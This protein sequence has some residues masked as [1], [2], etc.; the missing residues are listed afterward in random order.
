MFAQRAVPPKERVVEFR[1]RA[2]DGLLPVGQLLA[3]SWFREG[4]FVDARS[5]SKGHG[6]T[7]GMKR[8]GFHGQPASHGHSLSHRSMGSAGG[9]QG[10]GSRVL[11]GKKMAGRMGNEFVTIQ[12]LK[13]MKLDDEN[14]LIVVKGMVAGPKGRLVRLQDAKKKPWQRDDLKL[15]M[16][17][18]PSP[19]IMDEAIQDSAGNPQPLSG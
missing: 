9:S 14:G 6:F 17:L 15:P 5:E 11:P 10:S 3:P 8:W 7:G 19:P 4:Q 2:E 13:V 18:E 12:N 1:V 16:L